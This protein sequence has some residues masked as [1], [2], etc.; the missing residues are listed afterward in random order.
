MS[1]Y[2]FENKAGLL[3]YLTGEV[4]RLYSERDKCGQRTQALHQKSGE[5]R[6]HI[7]ISDMLKDSNVSVGN[8][9]ICAT[10]FRHAFPSETDGAV[11][12]KCGEVWRAL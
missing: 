11:C 4:K 2:V 3:D 6:A 9:V 5:I 7:A 8:P 12:T 10:E 1:T